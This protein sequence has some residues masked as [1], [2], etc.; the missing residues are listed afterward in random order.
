[1]GIQ[2]EGIAL[3]DMHPPQEVVPAYHEV[4]QAMERR[5]QRV[6]EAEADAMRETA[7]PRPKSCKPSAKQRRPR[8]IKFSKPP[9][10]GLNSWSAIQARTTLTP[11]QE[12][13]LLRD[14]V[15]AF[16]DGQDGAAVARDYQ[17][18]RGD[19]LALRK[20]GRFR[21]LLGNGIGGPGRPRQGYHRRRQ[22][23]G[24]HPP[25]ARAA[26]TVP[27]PFAQHGTAQANG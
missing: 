26:G 11:A 13:H 22:G 8:S 2:L 7:A 5:D 6:N 17:R 27:L 14:A 15:H 20:F 21:P 12:W 4:T 19:L 16:A 24:P 9:L 10:I 18:R 25:L 1:M 23:S 3:H